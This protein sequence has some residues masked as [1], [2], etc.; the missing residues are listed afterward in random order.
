MT[1]IHWIP[2]IYTINYLVTYCKSL[3]KDNLTLKFPTAKVRTIFECPVLNFVKSYFPASPAF[4]QRFDFT[5]IGNNPKKNLIS[6][7]SK[8]RPGLQH[9][10]TLAIT[11]FSCKTP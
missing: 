5:E 3:Y 1:S 8:T 7:K 9:L 11:R 2:A 4:A 10:E 6:V